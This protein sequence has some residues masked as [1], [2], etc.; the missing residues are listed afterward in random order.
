MDVG[1]A[2]LDRAGKQRVDDLGG[3]HVLDLGLEIEERLDVPFERLFVALADS[4]QVGLALLERQLVV[5]LERIAIRIVPDHRGQKLEGGR[6]LQALDRLDGLRVAGVDHAEPDLLAGPDVGDDPGAL[7][8]VLRDQRQHVRTDRVPEEP[9]ERQ[10]GLLSLGPALF[11]GLV[12]LQLVDHLAD[13]AAGVGSHVE[14]FVLVQNGG[15]A[16]GV[17]PLAIVVRRRRQRIQRTVLVSFLLLQPGDQ[18]L[19]MPHGLLA[20]RTGVRRRT[21]RPG[22]VVQLGLFLRSE[23]SRHGA[24]LRP[25]KLPNHS[26]FD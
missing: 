6:L 16:L 20:L 19:V 13:V 15:A 11:L 4:D 10:A 14:V 24:C 9:D 23:V 2:D 8:Q 26:T 12:R 25:Q 3:R 21:E 7:G 17:D 1:G 18:L 5:Q 22:E